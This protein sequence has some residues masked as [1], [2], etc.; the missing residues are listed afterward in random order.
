MALTLLVTYRSISDP[1]I[2][3]RSKI[4]RSGTSA[5]SRNA[6]SAGGNADTWDA[7][8]TLRNLESNLKSFQEHRDRLKG[9]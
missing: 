3:R 2:A 7:E 6:A 4:G 8:R 9:K 5:P 1:Q